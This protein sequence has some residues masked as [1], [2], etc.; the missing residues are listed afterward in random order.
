[1]IFIYRDTHSGGIKK[2]PY[3][4][5]IIKI[6]NINWNFID[7]LFNTKN[8]KIEWNDLIVPSQGISHTLGEQLA[9]YL[10][11]YRFGFNPVSSACEECCGC[12][13]DSALHYTNDSAL[14]NL[15]NE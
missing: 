3:D 15:Y 6:P 9:H 5:I 4:K 11:D 12:D 14:T 7:N 8:D 13:Y 2:T 1:M 10:F